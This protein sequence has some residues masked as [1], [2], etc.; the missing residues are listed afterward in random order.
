[1]LKQNLIKQQLFI[2]EIK[3]RLEV[4]S[5]LQKKQETVFLSLPPSSLS[6]SV[7]VSLSPLIDTLVN[8]RLQK[9]YYLYL[10]HRPRVSHQNEY[11][12]RLTFAFKLQIVINYY[13]HLTIPEL[14]TE[15][16]NSI[17]YNI[18]LNQIC[19]NCLLS[20]QSNSQHI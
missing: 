9:H 1:M 17:R 8:L 15:R 11:L 19:G 5:N 2:V 20:S 18:L 4:F 12:Q 16:T 10:I 14:L 6:V 7:C 13:Y 3:I